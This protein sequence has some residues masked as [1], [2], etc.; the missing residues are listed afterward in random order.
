M[1][2]ISNIVTRR[3]LVLL[4]DFLMSA[5]ALALTSTLRSKIKWKSIKNV[6]LNTG[7]NSKVLVNGESS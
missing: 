3:L 5:A 2:R 4:F 7:K 6:R 1:V